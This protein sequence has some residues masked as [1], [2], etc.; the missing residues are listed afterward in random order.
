MM[1][2]ILMQ[3]VSRCGPGVD[4]DDDDDELRQMSAPTG[5]PSVCGGVGRIVRRGVL[6]TALYSC[7]CGVGLGL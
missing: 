4:D 6:Y 5:G 3:F 1:M 2:M 7:W